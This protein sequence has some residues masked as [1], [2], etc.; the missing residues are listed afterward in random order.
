MLTFPYFYYIIYLSHFWYIL[1]QRGDYYLNKKLEDRIL[2]L[3][4]IKILSGM[5]LDRLLKYDREE[6]AEHYDEI[7]SVFCFL[8]EQIEEKCSNLSES[9]YSEY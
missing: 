5:S 8:N 6:L 3:E 1:L 7:I 2:D 9:F 4:R